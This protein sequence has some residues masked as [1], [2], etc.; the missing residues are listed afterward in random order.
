MNLGLR[1]AGINTRDL[2]DIQDATIFEA[3]LQRMQGEIDRTNAAMQRWGLTWHDFTTVTQDFVTEAG[4]DLVEM[5]DN[6]TRAGVDAGKLLR[7]MSGD[8]SQLVVDAVRTGS[9]LPASMRPLIE[10][11]IRTKKLSEAAARAL[12]GIPEDGTPAF[13]EISAAAQRYGIELDKLGPKINQLRI[14]E[15]AA[16]IVK[17]WD[18]LVGAGADVNAVLV[19]MQDEVQAV[20]IDAQKMGLA[21]PEAMRPII[22]K[23][24]D[25]GLLTDQFGNKLMD[26]SG[27]NFETPLIDKIDD[28]IEAIQL[29]ISTTTDFGDE[30]VLQYGRAREAAEILGRAVPRG[31]PGHRHPPAP[32]HHH[33]RRPAAGPIPIQ[34]RRRRR[35]CRR[36]PRPRRSPAGTAARRHMKRR[37]T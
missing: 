31:T 37:S 4:R 22:Q 29:L 21:I 17:D 5:F 8:L 10:E 13:A 7:G 6:M 28:L 18:L 26:T 3:T 33:H 20:V 1:L 14:R 11:L 34:R 9:K 25:A 19:G 2:W 27:L 35:R 16:Q 12:L 32:A 15:S 36:A 30:A 23:M 24:I